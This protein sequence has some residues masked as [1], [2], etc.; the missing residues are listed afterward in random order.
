MIALARKR[1][2]REQRLA[3]RR[4]AEGEAHRRGVLSAGPDSRR[5]YARLTAEEW[6]LLGQVDGE[7]ADY[8]VGNANQ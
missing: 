5:C 8:G 7:Y 6:D 4:V 3:A 2:R 1:R